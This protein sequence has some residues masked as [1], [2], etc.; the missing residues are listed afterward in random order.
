MEVKHQAYLQ[1]LN[2]MQAWYP[3]SQQVQLSLPQCHNLWLEIFNDLYFALAKSHLL[4]TQSS[5]WGIT[6][7]VLGL[8]QWWRPP[9]CGIWPFWLP[10]RGWRLESSSP[11]ITDNLC[12]SSHELWSLS[13]SWNSLVSDWDPLITLR[14]H[15]LTAS[16]GS[17]CGLGWDTELECAALVW[18]LK[19][20][21]HYTDGN[22]TLITNHLI[23]LVSCI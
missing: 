6:Y 2:I 13:I 14:A 17:L 12:L 15:L 1:L 11:I 23:F 16:S 4:T 7:P 22:F 8:V 5:C 10:S 21:P 3:R 9:L 20:H 19:K 18:A